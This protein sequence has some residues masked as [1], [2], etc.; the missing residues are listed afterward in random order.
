MR[1]DNK[2][3][4]A[5]KIRM[6][7]VNVTLEPASAKWMKRFAAHLPVHAGEVDEVQQHDVPVD[8]EGH[9]CVEPQ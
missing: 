9:Q 7:N 3:T 4:D 2:S 1:F 8:A 5:E 6:I